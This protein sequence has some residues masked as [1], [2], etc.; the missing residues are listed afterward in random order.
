MTLLQWLMV[1]VF[2][3]VALIGIVGLLTGR[4]RVKAIAA[5]KAKLKDIA[6]NGAAWPDEVLKFSNN[7]NN[8]FQTPMMFFATI[9][10]IIA[11]NVVDV[12]HVVLAF[13]F[14]AMRIAHTVVHT[15][16]NHVRL[17]FKVF[18]AGFAALFGMWAWLAAQVFL[19]V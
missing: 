3:Q 15:G 18:A 8:Q 11:L 16:S 4:V 19:K 13:V 2:V 14:V 17:R 5:G 7:L 6:L 10:I 12:V 9:G 1:P